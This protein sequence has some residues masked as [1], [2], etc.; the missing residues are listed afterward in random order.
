MLNGDNLAGNISSAQ[1]AIVPYPGHDSLY[2]IFTTD[3]LE[4]DLL[5]G[6]NYSIVNINHDNGK[7]EVIN[8]NIPLW[9]SCTERMAVAHHSNGVDLWLITNDK[10]SNV[11]RSWLIT[12]NGILPAHVISVTGAVL[13]QY[14]DINAG[15]IKVSPDGKTLCQTHFPFF[16]ELTHPPNFVQLFD[17]DNGTGVI[18]NPRSIS[19]SDAQYNHAEF[20]PN[21]KLLYLTRPSNKKIDQ[22]NISLPT[23]TAI[24]ASRVSFTTPRGYFDIQL[25]P[26]EKIYI[27]QPSAPLAVINQP[28]V[29][30]VGCN[31]REDQVDIAPGTAFIG[32]P[33]H[34]NDFVYADDPQNGFSFTILDSCT[35][36]VQFTA[37]SN[38]PAAITWEWDFGDGNTSNLQN[39][40]HTF[41]PAGRA[42]TVRLKISSSSSCGVI[43]K[44]KLLKPGGYLASKPDFDF[45]VRCDSGYVRFINKTPNLQ[46]LTAPQVWTF[47]DGNSSGST[48]PIHSYSGPG[49]YTV[50][51]KTNS[52]LACLDSSVS[53]PVEVKSFTVNLPPDQTIIVGQSVLLSTDQPAS[54]YEWSPST[55]L[56]GTN[57][58]NPVATPLEDITYKVK[59]AGA[60]GC[61]GEDSITI[62]VIQYKDIYVPSAFTPNND[63]KNDIIRPFYNGSLTLREF[64]VFSRWGN[65]VFTTAQRG[66]GWNGEVNGKLQDAGVYVWSVVLVDKNGAITEKKGTV[67]L[68]R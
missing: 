16:D 8:K 10:N 21:S 53:Y 14:R 29:A 54:T 26:D 25:G 18:S 60:E 67:V 12:C 19:F 61:K 30:G 49:I 57:I 33:F 7:G 51:L 62:H 47:G 5:G 44:S 63:G 42:Y 2:Y 38:F 37:R 31:F 48:H 36:K 23:M 32:L 56:S 46:N 50:K 11:F 40:L 3:A 24:L 34:I 59:A 64:S 15:V 66:S 4:N 43:Y 20:S 65:R 27:S 45:V 55:W 13:D 9:P 39:P 28:D 1:V 6:Y 41:S 68:I 22:L 17:F 52:G 35:G 58:R